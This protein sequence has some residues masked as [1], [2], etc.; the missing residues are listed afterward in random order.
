MT[1]SVTLP[2]VIPTSSRKHASQIGAVITG[3][4]VCVWLGVIET[5][6]RHLSPV[7]SVCLSVHPS[8]HPQESCL[9]STSAGSRG[10]RPGAGGPCVLSSACQASLVLLL[11][12]PSSWGAACS[13]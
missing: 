2:L 4:V 3:R 10:R 1:P 9:E 11:S 7:L 6:R 8:T 5:S 12:S 13:C